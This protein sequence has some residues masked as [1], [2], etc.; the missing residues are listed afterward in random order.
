MTGDTAMKDFSNM[1]KYFQVIC[2]K[3]HTLKGSHHCTEIN[4]KILPN[5]RLTK[6][7]VSSGHGLFDKN[8]TAYNFIHP[9]Q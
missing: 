4:K 8:I 6:N 7:D 1:K 5:G 2:T 9:K 3:A